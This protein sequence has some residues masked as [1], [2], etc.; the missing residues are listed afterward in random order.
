M[1]KPRPRKTERGLI[2]KIIYD[3]AA[4]KVIDNNQPVRKVAREYEMC[5]ISL[6]RYVKSLRNNL[7]PKVGYNPYNKV[8]TAEQELQLAQYCEKTVDLYFG[9]TTRDLRKLA[10][11][12]AYTNKLTHPKKWD[13]T[14]HAS[15]DWLVAFL[16]R[17]SHLTL[18]TPQAT[19]LSRAMNFNKENVS[20]FF[21]KLSSVLER[22]HFEPQNIYNIDETG[23]TTVQ[24]PTK[25]IAKKGTK[26][27]GSISSQERGTLVTLCLAVNAVGNA[28]P[29]MFVFPRIHFK[30]HFIRDGPI[31]CVGTGNK[32]G[33]MQ[34]NEFLAFMKHFVKHVNPSETNK[35]LILLDNHSSHLS[36]SLIDYCRDNF[37]TLLSFPPHTSHRLQP[38]DRGVYGPFKKYFNNAADQWMKNNPGKRM[39]IYDLPGIVK[40]S[41]P[42]ATT[43]NNII[44]GF[45][46]TGIWPFNREIFRDSDFA[47]S[48]VTD[49][50]LQDE[51]L[52]TETNMPDI[53]NQHK[54][55]ESPIIRHTSPL[56]SLP[57]PSTASDIT[58]TTGS[59]LVSENNSSLVTPEIL[60]PLPKADFAKSKKGGKMKRKTAILTDTPEKL[61]IEAQ[62]LK[63]KVPMKYS[64]DQVQNVKE[65]S[66]QSKT[67]KKKNRNISKKKSAPKDDTF[68][69]SSDEETLCLVCFGPY[70]KSTEDWLQCRECKKWAHL[71]CSNK[72]PFYV[73]INC[74]SDDD[75]DY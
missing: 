56:R 72:S 46:C 35:V 8:F 15:E 7:Q 25:V 73:C 24:K 48:T 57:G 5:H 37:I 63:K 13:E 4:R 45:S 71:N 52:I 49:R 40:S 42:L 51:N 21:N 3:E 9:L 41:L 32:S 69:D 75:D 66:L 44:A 55:P 74:N 70:S 68:S 62:N 47:P 39:T 31:G 67:Q 2:P 18:R 36:I 29:P 38:L 30:D 58:P 11:Q 19:S 17:H 10:F 60:K 61:L 33:W 16:R 27:V 28:V 65:K 34:E 43:P 59:L 50:P 1:V 22:H 64:L 23:V 14:E 53:E 20:S 6:Y 12:F 54:N 26:Q